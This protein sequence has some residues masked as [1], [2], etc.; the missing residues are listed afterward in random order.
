[1]ADSKAYIGAKIVRA[2]PAQQHDRGIDG[3]VVIYPDGYTS[4]CPK[5]TFETAYRE[6]TGGEKALVAEGGAE[7]NAVHHPG[8]R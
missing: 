2:Y 7:L 4:W 1:M 6:V 8:S 3:Y 5:D